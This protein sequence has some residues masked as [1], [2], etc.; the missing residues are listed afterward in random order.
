MGW[1]NVRKTRRFF[2]IPK[3]YKIVALI[4]MGRYDN[5]PSREKKRKKMEEI[6]WFN[7]VG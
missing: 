5:R 3:K 2:N 4:A 7:K 6:V 1:F